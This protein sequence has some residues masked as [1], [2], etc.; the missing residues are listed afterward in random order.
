[1]PPPSPSTLSAVF[2]SQASSPSPSSSSPQTSK[3]AL[4]VAQGRAKY[5]AGD[6]MGALALFESALK[7]VRPRHRKSVVFVISHLAPPPVKNSRPLSPNSLSL[8]S[9][10]TNDNPQSPSA[11][12]AAAASWNATVV[13]C[14][15]GDVELAQVTLREALAAGLDFDAALRAEGRRVTAARVDEVAAAVAE[16]E[17]SPGSV[18]DRASDPAAAAAAALRLPFAGS[19]QVASQL[20]KFARAFA[21]AS[22]SSSGSSG[23]SAAPPSYSSSSSSSP[24]SPIS[25][26]GID[27]SPAAIAKR[28]AVLLAALIGLGVGLFLYGLQ[29]L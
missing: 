24:S 9:S 6:R 28:V 17:S 19:P 5:A 10:L 13:H 23:R 27:A 4:L 22:S 26:D 7:Q 1:M 14:S 15:F 8:P 21:R 25:V 20:R 12:E 11:P 18:V 3:A 16:N 29:Y 2:A